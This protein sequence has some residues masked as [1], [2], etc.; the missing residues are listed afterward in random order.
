[1]MKRKMMVVLACIMSMSIA[2]PVCASEE[3][4]NGLETKEVQVVETT[5]NINVGTEEPVTDI[6][7]R[8]LGRPTASMNLANGGTLNFAGTSAGYTL[9]TN[10]SVTGKKTYKITVRNRNKKTLKVTAMTNGNIFS[11]KSIGAGKTAVYS[12]TVNKT[13]EKMYLKFT[14]QSLNFEG[15]IR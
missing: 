2:L 10:K 14:G 1:M 3:Q 11:T 5:D 13:S 15:S 4:N 6:K 12:T 7:E 9:Y 8:G